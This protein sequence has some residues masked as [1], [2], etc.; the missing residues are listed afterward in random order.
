MDEQ[1]KK[2]W[3]RHH[4]YREITWHISMTE[5]EAVMAEERRAQTGLS[6]AEF[7]RQALTTGN[8]ISRI[9]KEDRKLLADL[10]HMRADINRLVIICEKNG[11]NTI[12]N[13]ILRIEDQFA[14]FY[15]YIISRI[16]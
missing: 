15:N 12:Q 6:K 10:S 11:T 14:D 1:Q 16:G 9:N 2:K 13:R 7:G 3:L 5:E 8:V 4:D